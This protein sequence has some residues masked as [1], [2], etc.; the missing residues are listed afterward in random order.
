[1]TILN[2]VL[3]ITVGVLPTGQPIP[4]LVVRRPPPAPRKEA[5]HA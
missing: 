3:A 4:I 5:S 2:A 1:M